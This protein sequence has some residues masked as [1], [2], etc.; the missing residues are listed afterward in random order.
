MDGVDVANGELT[1][2]LVEGAMC[3]SVC[4]PPGL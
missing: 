4:L 1:F 3:D 2:N